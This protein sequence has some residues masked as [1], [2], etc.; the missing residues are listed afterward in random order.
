[1]KKVVIT[2]I[3]AVTAIGNTAPE[4]WENLIAGKCGMRTITRIP[5]EGHDSTVAA[6]VDS[7]F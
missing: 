7:S 6:E 2:G 1:M 3:G 5:I 4:Y